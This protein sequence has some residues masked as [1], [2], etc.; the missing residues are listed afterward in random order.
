MSAKYKLSTGDLEDGEGKMAL[1]KERAIN[2]DESLAELLKHTSG[3]SADKLAALKDAFQKNVIGTN[4]DGIY[5]V[6]MQMMSLDVGFVLKGIGGYTEVYNE[7]LSSLETLQ[8]EKQMQADMISKQSEEM[9]TAFNK[10]TLIA[11]VI[12]ILLQLS[13][14][15]LII[16]AIV[17]S[18]KDISET[19]G[20]LA[21]GDT[22]VD[23]DA[24]ERKDELGTIVESLSIFKSNQIEVQR[25][26]EEQERQKE[27]QE[28]LR[29]Q[30]MLELADQFD[31][32]VSGTIQSLVVSAEELKEASTAMEGTATKTQES[33]TTVSRASEATSNN[34]ATVS[35]ATDQMTES[36]REISQQITDVA[37]KAT[38]ASHEA[39]NASDKVDNLNTLIE[40]IG[41]VV[42]SIRDIAE[43]TNLLAL[44]ATIEAARAG[45]A[46]K[47]FAVVAEE[48]GQP[49]FFNPVASS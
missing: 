25:L 9:V 36:A 33:S 3:E 47:G 21:T 22:N 24:L 45:D 2:M 29:K 41:E 31:A 12:A 32:Q 48:V 15:L 17:K 42:T 40:N 28:A 8:A 20:T 30:A 6:A 49:P 44:N 7:F 11:S 19:T 14:S 35:L 43:Q 38:S 1:L 27:E 34:V 26:K 18:V 23:I 46:G 5:D 13:I 37:A 16:W 10:K 4:D 39:N